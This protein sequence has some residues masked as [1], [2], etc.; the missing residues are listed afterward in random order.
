MAKAQATVFM[1]IGIIIVLI[2]ALLFLARPTSTVENNSFL[3]NAQ[4]FVD[5]CYLQAASCA[6]AEHSSQQA[7]LQDLTV[8]LDQAEQTFTGRATRCISTFQYPGIKLNVNSITPTLE[9]TENS[10]SIA[11]QNNIQQQE[12]GAIR[13]LDNYQGQ[14]PVR[15]EP[16]H[17]IAMREEYIN[18]AEGIE[19][20]GITVCPTAVIYNDLAAQEQGKEYQMMVS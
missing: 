10:L 3:G 4:S 13:Q 12:K 6:V 20:L 8:L 11:V 16:I 17:R 7:Q 15:V 19:S 5:N 1:I 14:L 18:P 2:I 9:A